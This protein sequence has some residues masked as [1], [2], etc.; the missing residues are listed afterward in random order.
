MRTKCLEQFQCLIVR[1]FGSVQVVSGPIEDSEVSEVTCHA[2]FAAECF[3]DGQGLI[4]HLFGSVQV[5]SGLIDVSEVSV[6]LSGIR[7]LFVGAT[8]DQVSIDGILR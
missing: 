6:G 5:A 7:R 3:I 2:L 1:L 4:V 8:Q